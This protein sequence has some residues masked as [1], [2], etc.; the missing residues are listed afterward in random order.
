MCALILWRSGLVLLIGK[1]VQ[2]LTELSA[3]DRSLFSFPDDNLRNYELIFTKL[4]VCIDIVEVCF[5]I[6]VG[7]ISPV[8]LDT[9]VFSFLDDNLSNINGFS[10]NLVSALLLWTSALGLLMGKFRSFWTELSAR[11]TSVSYF[12]NNNVSKSQWIFT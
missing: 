5:G 11:R 10:P 12:Q 2:F 6:A 1:F 9:S 8:T 7:Q 4:G 3:R